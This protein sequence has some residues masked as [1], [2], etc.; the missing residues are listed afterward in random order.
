MISSRQYGAGELILRENEAGETAYIIER[1]RVEITKKLDGQ[2]IHL[3]YLDAGD[4]FGEMSMVDDKPR[5]ATVKALQETVVREIH[6]DGFFE[7]L[8]TDPQVAVDLLKVLFER[9]READTTILQMQKAAPQPAL[10]AT[11]EPALS[12]KV[13][14]IVLLEGMTPRATR[15]LPA[16]PF[17]INKFPFRIGRLSRDP[18]VNNDLSIPDSVPLEISRHHVALIRRERRIGVSDRGSTLGSW[19]DGRQLGGAKGDPG[20][21]FFEDPEGTLVLGNKDSPFSYKVVIRTQG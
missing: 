18:L 4:V 10:R 17:Q 6:R 13:E 14:T 2:N 21:L 5:H 3:A 1:G 11:P 16:T 15:A 12:A 8:Q 20:P 19:V 7:S 9:L